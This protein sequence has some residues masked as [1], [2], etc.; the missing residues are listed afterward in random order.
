MN[1]V[2]T[3]GFSFIIPAYNEERNIRQCIESII[4]EMKRCV[5][6]NYEIIVVDNNCTDLTAQIAR[7]A[8]ARVVT[9][10]NKGIVWARS[11]GASWASYSHLANIDADN[12]MPIGWG[13]AALEYLMRPEVVVVS[14]PLEY[15]DLG[16]FKSLVVRSFYAIGKVAHHVIHPFCQG[17]NYIIRHTVY[18]RMGGYDTNI[19]FYG[20]DT[21]TAYK[22]KAFGKI[23]VDNR[24]KIMSSSR[25]FEG[26]GLL[27]TGWLYAINFMSV[28]F[29]RRP[30]TNAYRDFR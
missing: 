10:A 5:W 9:E 12:I 30:A 23:I 20:E 24:L 19:P 28:S 21:M 7:D 29:G 16:W 4:M 25:R 13:D 1:N 27:L 18:D 6:H 26:Q 3:T 15:T 11:R 2:Y 14:G 17:G 8:G 22:A